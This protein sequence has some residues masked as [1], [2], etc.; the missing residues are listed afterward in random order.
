MK[1]GQNVPWLSMRKSLWG[2]LTL[3]IFSLLRALN[4]RR[5]ANIQFANFKIDFLGNQWK[6][7]KSL[8]HFCSLSPTDWHCAVC[9]VVCASRK[10]GNSVWQIESISRLKACTRLLLNQIKKFYFFYGYNSHKRRAGKWFFG[11]HTWRSTLNLKFLDRDYLH[12]GSTQIVKVVFKF[13]LYLTV[14]P[15]FWGFYCFT[16]CYYFFWGR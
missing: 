1:F 6:Y 15:P 2:F 9:F 10:A 16:F 8:T 14:F 5:S 12:I 11:R 13:L 4:S 3:W 7:W